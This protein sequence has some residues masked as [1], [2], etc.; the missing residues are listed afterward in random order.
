MEKQVILYEM[1][2]GRAA[3]CFPALGTGLDVID[4]GRK[5]TPEGK[6]FIVENISD[7]PEDRDK[8]PAMELDLT[9]PDGVGMTP[10]E[11]ASH[12]KAIREARNHGQN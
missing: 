11:W 4:I 12:L 9:N 5:C 1:A 10:D 6:P 7:L 8:W 2:D 3:V